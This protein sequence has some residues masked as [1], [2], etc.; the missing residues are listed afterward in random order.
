MTSQRKPDC[1]DWGL[2]VQ[3]AVKSKLFNSSVTSA[4]Q[5]NMYMPHCSLRDHFEIKVIDN[6]PEAQVSDIKLFCF[7]V[8][9]VPGT[10]EA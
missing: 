4:P 3:S 6:L 8:D 2:T 9:K 1:M 10:S 5:P 7:C